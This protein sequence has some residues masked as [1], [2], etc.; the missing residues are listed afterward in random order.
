[1][2]RKT[3][4]EY[5]NDNDMYTNQEI[6]L[7]NYLAL[8]FEKFNTMKR[9][10]GAFYGL[11]GS[12]LETQETRDGYFYLCPRKDPDLTNG[13][14]ELY[15]QLNSHIFGKIQKSVG[16]DKEF[17]RFY[18]NVSHTQMGT[19]KSFPLY[20]ILF[21]TVNKHRQIS[22]MRAVEIAN[23]YDLLLGRDTCFDD[24]EN[25]FNFYYRTTFRHTFDFFDHTLP[26]NLV[27]II[28]DKSRKRENCVHN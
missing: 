3:L 19:D 1:M 23:R 27:D 10:F 9:I 16:I 13:T 15:R 6:W 20:H 21:E 25:E 28:I 5:C 2:I 26:K 17:F 12:E 11:S 24:I 8:Y 18:R 22:I 7:K 14:R 4:P